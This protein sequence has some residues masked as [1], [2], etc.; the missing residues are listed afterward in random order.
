MRHDPGSGTA[1]PDPRAPPRGAAPQPRARLRP[2]GPATSRT[3]SPASPSSIGI[4]RPGS[5]STIEAASCRA[6]VTRPIR[7]GPAAGGP[8]GPW[9]RPA[10]AGSIDSSTSRSSRRRARSMS[11][12]TMWFWAANDSRAGGPTLSA[13]REVRGALRRPRRGLG[14]A[15]SGRGPRRIVERRGDASLGPRRRACQMFGALLGLGDDLGQSRMDRSATVGGR[16]RVRGGREQRMGEAESVAIARPAPRRVRR[17]RARC[18]HLRPDRR[19]PAGR[20]SGATLAGRDTAPPSQ[21]P[22]RDRRAAGP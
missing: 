7:P 19:R 16:P 20:W 10:P 15:A 2:A 21:H 8:A 11:P 14:R 5:S 22:A 4:R 3:P 9:P 12:A 17:R 18:G 1:R 13:R 6:P